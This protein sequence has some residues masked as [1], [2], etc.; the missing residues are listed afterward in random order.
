LDILIPIADAVAYAHNNGVLHRDIKPSNIIFTQEN[1]PMLTDFGIAKVLETSEG[2]LT[3]TGLGVGTP[4][5]MAPEQWQGKASAA[6]DQYAL[7]VLLYEM[8]TGHKPYTAETPLAV[9]IKQINEPLQRPRYFVPDIPEDVEKIIF[10]ALALKPEDRYE[11]VSSLCDRL[12]SL[13]AE[14]EEK[15]RVA[16]VE[17]QIDVEEAIEDKGVLISPEV[18]TRDFGDKVLDTSDMT[19]RHEFVP[20]SPEVL[21]N[22]PKIKRRR[23]KGQRQ[24]THLSDV[25]QSPYLWLSL[26]VL[27]IITAAWLSFDYVWGSNLLGGVQNGENQITLT[28]TPTDESLIAD[29]GLVTDEIGFAK[30]ATITETFAVSE[31]ATEEVT[32]TATQTMTVTFTFIPPT[33]T[34]I[35][36]TNPPKPTAT[37]PPPP[38]SP[39]P[40]SPPPTSPPLPTST[41]PPPPTATNPPAPT[42]TSES[43][44]TREPTPTPP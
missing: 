32:A 36:P 3:G 14:L 44:P 42:N 28:S 13:K 16:F 40:T 15:A 43:L 20:P 11:N 19:P 25:L 2:T 30:T 22:K 34:R 10:K 31:S 18:E 37:N 33:A 26:V 23:A 35:P 1:V 12:I 9:A 24:K 8:T 27:L 29:E 6:S 21:D 38:T 5:Y 4:E 17:D 39:P 7:G 41:N